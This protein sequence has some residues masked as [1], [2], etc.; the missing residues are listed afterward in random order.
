[1]S[2]SASK[3]SLRRSRRFV[4]LG[5]GVFSPTK[6]LS[7]ASEGCGR[8]RCWDAAISASLAAIAVSTSS[9][10]ARL[11]ECVCASNTFSDIRRDTKQRKENQEP[12]IAAITTTIIMIKYFLL[13]HINDD[14]NPFCPP[15][16]FVIIHHH[17]SS[18]SIFRSLY[19]ESSFIVVK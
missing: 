13:S 5:F 3:I 2:P 15:S 11:F 4:S 6:R 14:R 8:G 9:R 12:S 17:S 16:S 1:M 18:F 7:C 19:P 10:C